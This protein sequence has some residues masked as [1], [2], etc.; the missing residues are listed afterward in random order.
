VIPSQSF[1]TAFLFPGC[2]LLQSL[3]G[4]VLCTFYSLVVIYYSQSEVLCCAYFIPWL[5]IKLRSHRGAFCAAYSICWP[6]SWK[7]VTH[8][9]MFNVNRSSMQRGYQLVTCRILIVWFLSMRSNCV[10]HKLRKHLTRV[11]TKNSY[12]SK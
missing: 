5:L 8:S 1:T 3:W 4:A 11:G 6:S 10:G 7:Y 2:H 12:S 9:S